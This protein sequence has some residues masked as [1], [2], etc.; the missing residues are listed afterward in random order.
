MGCFKTIIDSSCA[1]AA[2]AWLTRLVN[3]K[4]QGSNPDINNLINGL[5][6]IYRG[7]RTA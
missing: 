6:V 2:Q 3:R 5:L 7:S 4:C 1:S